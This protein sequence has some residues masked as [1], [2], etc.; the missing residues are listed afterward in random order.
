MMSY[1]P[2]TKG[3]GSTG[4]D[5]MAAVEI[6][7]AVAGDGQEGAEAEQADGTWESKRQGISAEKN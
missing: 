2:G 6:S 1:R 3:V 4:K 5:T 7:G